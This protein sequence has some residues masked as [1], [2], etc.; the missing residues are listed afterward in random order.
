MKVNS[1]SGRSR[2]KSAMPVLRANSSTEASVLGGAASNR[3][4]CHQRSKSGS[5][6]QRGGARRIGGSTTLCRNPGTSRVARSSRSGSRSQSGL[7]LSTTTTTTVERSSGSFS[8]YQEKASESLMWTGVWFSTAGSTFRCSDATARSARSAGRRCC[9]PD[10]RARCRRTPTHSAA[11]GLG[12]VSAGRWPASPTR[13]HGAVAGTADGRWPA[14]WT[15]AFGCSRPCL[16]C[17]SRDSGTNASD[18]HERPWPTMVVTVCHPSFART[19]RGASPAPRREATMSTPSTGPALP[20]ASP[21]SASVAG[22]TL[23]DSHHQWRREPQRLAED[24]PHIVVLMSRRCR[25]LGSG[26]LRRSGPH[27]DHASVWPT[28]GCGST[29]STPR[30]SARRP[31][32]RC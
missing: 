4:T 14:P 32:R 31:G 28:G 5:T 27:A 20:F 29:G 6:T 3:R 21:P 19:A 10:P 13:W 9:S 24:P 15:R 25:V 7:P 2:S 23:A 1:H 26:V 12:P 30:R 17:S 11:P 8:M 18:P 16:R 22:R